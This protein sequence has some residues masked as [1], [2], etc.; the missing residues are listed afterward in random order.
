MADGSH[1]RGLVRRRFFFHSIRYPAFSF[2]SV[3]QTHI[4][5][6]RTHSTPRILIVVKL[7]R[8]QGVMNLNRRNRIRRM[9]KIVRPPVSRRCSLAVNDPLASDAFVTSPRGILL[10]VKLLLVR[11]FVERRMGQKRVQL[12]SCPSVAQSGSVPY[13][14][15]FIMLKRGL[16]KRISML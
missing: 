13:G 6:P 8:R 14:V 5:V 7:C 16:L 4:P 2:H 10:A 9:E 12:E 11:K 15:L 3:R 1:G